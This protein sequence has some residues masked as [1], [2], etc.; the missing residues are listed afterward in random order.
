MTLDSGNL[1]LFDPADLLLVQVSVLVVVLGQ[2]L[3]IVLVMENV[4]LLVL[5]PNACHPTH[6]EVVHWLP[7]DLAS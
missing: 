6:S 7:E 3:V 5:G 4:L 2:V 1:T